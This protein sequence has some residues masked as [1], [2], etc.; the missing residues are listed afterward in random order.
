M[1]EVYPIGTLVGLIGSEGVTG[2][3]T[4][5]YIAGTENYV[6][7]CVEWWDSGH[8]C[9]GNFKEYQ[10]VPD[11]D[12]KKIAIGFLAKPKPEDYPE[13]PQPVHA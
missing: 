6:T 1:I 2:V 5:I 3:I 13:D 9:E 7:Y 4:H 10:F 8:P 12:V 11:A